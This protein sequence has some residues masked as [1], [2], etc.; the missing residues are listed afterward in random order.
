MTCPRP[1]AVNGV[2]KDFLIRRV[3]PCLQSSHPSIILNTIAQSLRIRYIGRSSPSMTTSAPECDPAQSLPHPL[4][5]RDRCR[6][7]CHSCRPVCIFEIR[8]PGVGIIACKKCRRLVLRILDLMSTVPPY[9]HDQ[10]CCNSR[11]TDKSA[12]DSCNIWSSSTSSSV[13]VWWLRV[14]QW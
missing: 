1:C 7:E 2:Q 5:K 8:V 14:W 13:R 6:V 11:S 9:S 12:N 4:T 3:R 10:H